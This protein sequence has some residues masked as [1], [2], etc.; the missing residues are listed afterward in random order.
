MKLIGITQRIDNIEYYSERRD[1][2]DQKWSDFFYKLGYIVIPLPNISKDKAL[3]L[4]GKLQLDAILLSGG[5]SISHLNPLA[6]D[7]APERD[8]FE[9]TL[10]KYAHNEK[11]P[12][13]GVCRGMQLINVYLGG[14]LSPVSAHIA[15]RHPV[16]F[17][18]SD[19]QLKRIVNSYHA[20][21]IKADELA[22]TLKVIA[23]DEDGCIEAFESKT[24]RVLGLM[25]HPE[26]EQEFNQFDLQFIG[27]FL[28]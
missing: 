9:K 6:K 24:S 19:K 10:I 26:R 20:W 28:K 12:L 3:I 7:V 25:W 8:E 23:S 27:Q 1:C 15:T 17:H 2:L 11:L 16:N 13:I 14:A 22:P 4:L 18:D 5:N 21:G